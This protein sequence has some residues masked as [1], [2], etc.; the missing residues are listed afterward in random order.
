LNVLT[1]NARVTVEHRP[2]KNPPGGD[3]PVI[4]V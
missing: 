2:P 4:D 1:G 3:G